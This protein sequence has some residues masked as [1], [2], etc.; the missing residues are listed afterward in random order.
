MK[1]AEPPDISEDVLLK[2]RNQNITDVKPF[3]NEYTNQLSHKI[4]IPNNLVENQNNFTDHLDFYNEEHTNKCNIKINKDL[5]CINFNKKDSKD[6]NRCITFPIFFSKDVR[7]FID[8]QFD[9]FETYYNFAIDEINKRFNNK[10]LEFNNSPTCIYKKIRLEKNTDKKKSKDLKIIGIDTCIENK[11]NSS[12]FCEKHKEEKPLWELNISDSSI[13][14][15]LIFSTEK[16]NNLDGNHKLKKFIYSLYEVRDQAIKYA[17]RAYKSA[18][19]NLI[20]GNISSFQLKTKDI[21][22]K[23]RKRIFESTASSITY[24]TTSKQFTLGTNTYYKFCKDINRIKSKP[25]INTKNNAKE[26]IE[27]NYNGGNFKIFRTCSGKYFII[28]LNKLEKINNKNRNKIISIDPGVRSF[29]TGYDPNGTIIESYN[30]IIYRIKDNYKRIDNNNRIIS[31]KDELNLSSKKYKKLKRMNNKKYNKIKNMVDDMHNKVS[32]YLASNYET[33]L[34]PPLK[35]KE[36]IKGYNAPLLDGA[37][38][39]AL[40]A[41]KT[42]LLN[43]LSFYMFTNKLISQSEKHNTKLYLVTEA[44]TS[45]TCTKCGTINDKL[46]DSKIFKCSKCKLKIDRDHNGAR[47]I[48]LKH[49]EWA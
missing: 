38:V 41:R 29:I 4:W 27:K 35:V 39:N 10:K 21:S 44:F 46:K 45:K 2:Y 20:S 47:N 5:E 15:S 8:I 13:R 7:D 3:Y 24:D 16:L 14:H 26:W 43:T 11:C 42:R 19:S 40:K 31:K 18:V 30:E 6:S 17:V 49:I 48:L 36:I 34:Y 22:K 12:W 33:I 32:N 25:I 28:L 23:F 1:E 9:A 37:R